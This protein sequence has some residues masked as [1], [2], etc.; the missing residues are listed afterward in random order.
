MTRRHAAG[1]SLLEAVVTLVIVSLLVAVLMQALGHALNLR[2]RLLRLQGEARTDFLQ[3]AWFRETVG[4][5]QADLDDALGTME[6][7]RDALSYVTPVPLV[8]QGMSQ[9]RWWLAGSADEASLHY[10]DN[11]TPDLIVVPGPLRDASFSY[12]GRDGT[13]R[14]SWKPE[15]ADPE[16]LPRLVRFEATTA[17]GRL[18]WLVPLLSDPIPP[19][20]LRF[21]EV[22]SDL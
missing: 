11:A 15:P 14:D 10:A 1:F 3:E 13:W 16:R 18:Y 21:D 22:N 5:A 9:V 6:G 8:G 12:L 17:R 7:G 20:L 4:A 2:T 19:A